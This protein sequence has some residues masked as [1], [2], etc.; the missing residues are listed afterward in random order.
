[1]NFTTLFGNDQILDKISGAMESITKQGI[2]LARPN[3][4]N[5]PIIA[6]GIARLTHR[7]MNFV[8]EFKGLSLSTND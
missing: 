6:D 3:L 1:M 2:V 4:D 5:A 7:F 8:G